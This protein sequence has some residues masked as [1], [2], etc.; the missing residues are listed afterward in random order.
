[1]AIMTHALKKKWDE[2]TPENVC[3]IC[4]TSSCRV[5]AVDQ[6]GGSYID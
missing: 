5:K 6:N 1:M 3:D 4:A 2:I